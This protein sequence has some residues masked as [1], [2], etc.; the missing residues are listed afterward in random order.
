LSAAPGA[1]G[2]QLVH[3]LKGCSPRVSGAGAL[4]TCGQS[5][6]PDRRHHRGCSLSGHDLVT[7]R[8]SILPSSTGPESGHW[9]SPRP[10]SWSPA[11]AGAIDAALGGGVGRHLH[12]QCS[13]LDRAG[14]QAVP[15]AD[16]RPGTGAPNPDI[17]TNL[18]KSGGA[19]RQ[20]RQ[21]WRPAVADRGSLVPR[22][23][24]LS[25]RGPAASLGSGLRRRGPADSR[26]TGDCTPAG[27]GS[28]CIASG[29]QW[30]TQRPPANSPAGAG[31]WLCSL[32]S[33]CDLS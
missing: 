32:C 10:V 21:R 27:S 22:A 2:S 16:R 1:V 9:T 19:D 25:R 20:N 28:A 6:A 15:G 3:Y 23:P 30:R 11:Y 7:D 33:I 14:H 26:R 29:R 18:C 24:V 13:A 17:P 31:H 4:L 5:G 12:S 8:G